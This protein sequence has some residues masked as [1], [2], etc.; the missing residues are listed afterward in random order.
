VQNTLIANTTAYY[1]NQTNSAQPVCSNNNYFE[2][3][4]FFTPAYVTNAKIDVSGNH[5]TLDP[6]FANA[7]AGDFKLS[8]QTLIDNQIGDPRWRQ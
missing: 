7:A 3:I 2:A 1:T 8:N 6:G 5:T 4:G